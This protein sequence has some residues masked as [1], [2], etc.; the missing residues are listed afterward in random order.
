MGKLISLHDQVTVL[1]STHNVS[2]EAV[3]VALRA[4]LCQWIDTYLDQ[5]MFSSAAPFVHR[6]VTVQRKLLDFG[7]HQL[8]PDPAG[9]LVHY[10]GVYA[11]V[12][13]GLDPDNNLPAPFIVA[14]DT[15][16][17]L[18]S[19]ILQI[20]ELTDTTENEAEARVLRARESVSRIL[21]AA[22]E[23]S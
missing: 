5:E 9:L 2:P 6:L 7:V 17:S 3:Y 14:F 8:G 21:Q 15:L 18:Q 16:M 20:R 19:A 1:A 11:D 4:K 10:R 23:A 13:D 12:L 22:Q